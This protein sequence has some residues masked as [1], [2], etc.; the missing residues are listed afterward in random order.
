[1]IPDYSH[2]IAI[3]HFHNTVCGLAMKGLKEEEPETAEGN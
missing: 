3:D 2:V 1:M